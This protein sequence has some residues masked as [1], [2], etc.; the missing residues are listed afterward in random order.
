MSNLAPRTTLRERV[1]GAILDAAAVVLAAREHA[2][3]SEV[4]E[5]AG[6]A[7]ATLY[8]Y[9]PTR[10]ALLE[11]LGRYGLEQ[12]GGALESAGLERVPVGEGF[13]RAVRALVTV[14]DA[15]IVLARERPH[16]EA[17]DFERRV[18][19]PLRA[20]VERGQAE[21]EIRD[22]VPAAWL[23]ESLLALVVSVL[24]SSPAMGPE[25]T[26]H[27]IT[28]LFLDGARGPREVPSA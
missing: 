8:R 23:I 4:A 11:D 3:M 26:V 15:F 16:A 2:S 6:V 7:R 10:E 1:A 19:A 27:A 20:L 24:P 5:A 13:E 25:D 17:G 22:D 18:S 28:G 21:G 14:G 12:A 9:F